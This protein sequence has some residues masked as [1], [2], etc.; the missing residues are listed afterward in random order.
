[1]K[2]VI[3]FAALLCT[4][5]SVNK[6]F[7]QTAIK[8]VINVWGNCGMCKSKIEKAAKKAGAS[9]AIWNED[10]KKLTVKYSKTKSSSE[11]IQQAIAN[12]G[13]D[14]ELFTAQDKVYNALPGCCQYDRKVKK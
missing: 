6:S 7:A 13:Y 9:T 1:M 5:F 8:E 3:I 12:V 11:K 14:T 4:I 10:T 2:K